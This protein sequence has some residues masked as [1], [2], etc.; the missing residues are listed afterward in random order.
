MARDGLTIDIPASTGVGQIHITAFPIPLPLFYIDLGEGQSSLVD[1][2]QNYKKIT[3]TITE[4]NTFTFH[5]ALHSDILVYK[6]TKAIRDRV[7]HGEKLEKVLSEYP[8]EYAFEISQ[9]IKR[10]WHLVF[11]LAQKKS[12]GKWILL[13]HGNTSNVMLIDKDGIIVERAEKPRLKLPH[14]DDPKTP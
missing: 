13:L 6:I 10:H 5:Y 7:K 1:Q 11:E 4:I 9:L 2:F 3:L 8:S 12:Q 14:I